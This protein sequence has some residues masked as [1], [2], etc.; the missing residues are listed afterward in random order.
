M[1]LRLRFVRGTAWDSRVIEYQTRCWCSHVEYVQPENRVTFGA[2]LKGG[3]K[4]RP[5]NDPCYRDIARTETWIL[6]T[7]MFQEEA[8][9]RFIEQTDGTAYDW[10]AILSFGLGSRDWREPDSWFC[11]EWTARLLELANVIT[12][13]KVLPITRITPRDIYLLF[14][15]VR[16]C[17]MLAQRA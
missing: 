5:L 11:S 3:V 10:R 12:F 9:A 6:Q 16:G 7:A 14:S 17:K 15:Q 13:P 4:R 1:A 2:Q 8:I